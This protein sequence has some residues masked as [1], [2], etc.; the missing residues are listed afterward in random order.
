MRKYINIAVASLLTFG[1][2]SCANIEST[3]T[4]T[5][6]NACQIL[7]KNKDWFQ[8][9]RLVAEKWG[10]PISVQLSV[11]K[12]ESTFNGDASATTSSAYGYAQALTGTF[13][14]Y[15]KETNNNNASR[16]SYSDSV[17]FI[18]WYFSKTTK[19]LRHSAYDAET[20][21]LA[22]HDGIGGFRNGTHKKKPWL[23]EKAKK[24]QAVANQYRLQIN[25][26]RLP[27]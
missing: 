14:E 3:G 10:I 26:C 5:P 19:S 4:N 27:R 13:N 12:H 7:M 6:Y 15:K 2:S 25:K 21:Y 1:L 11:I 9:S 23:V 8:A 16:G 18:G 20:F 24:V 17:D 22:Y